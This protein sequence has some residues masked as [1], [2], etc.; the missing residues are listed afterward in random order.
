[1]DEFI[2]PKCPLNL[3][4][5]E[6]Q[7]TEIFGHDRTISENISGGAETRAEHTQEEVNQFSNTP[8]REPSQV[9][10]NIED[11]GQIGEIET[12]QAKDRALVEQ[13]LD[14]KPS[15]LRVEMTNGTVVPTEKKKR[16]IKNFKKE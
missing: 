16:K 3:N 8:P 4:I 1:M 14:E 5:R 7:S 9:N 11:V 2:Q 10:L 15:S 6:T 13:S 12:S